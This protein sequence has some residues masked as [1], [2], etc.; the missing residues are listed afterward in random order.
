MKQKK[1]LFSLAALAGAMLVY[2]IVTYNGFVKKEEMVT[3]YWADVERNYQRRAD[4]IPVLVQTVK[5]MAGYE[6]ETLERIAAARARLATIQTGA[7]PSPETVQEQELLQTEIATQA[8][9]L[10]AVI[11]SYPAIRGT[12]AFLGLQTQLEGTERRIKIARKDYNEAVNA[13]NVAVRSF[14]SSVVAKIAGFTSRPGFA[15][16]IGSEKAV[17]IKF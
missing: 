15:S 8:N 10:I 1:W 4:L 14:P 3:K 17:E 6:K 9:R 13:F 5:G 16:D 11:E 7:A 2:G 12:E